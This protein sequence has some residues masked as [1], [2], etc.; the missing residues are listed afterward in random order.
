M[1]TATGDVMTRNKRHGKYDYARTRDFLLHMHVGVSKQN[2]YTE[3][4]RPGMS[5]I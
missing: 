4:S 3:P 2:I 5:G 1:L